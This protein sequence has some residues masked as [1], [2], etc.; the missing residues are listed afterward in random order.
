MPTPSTAGARRHR[1]W[2]LS[3][4]AL[5]AVTTLAACGSSNH[6]SSGSGSGSGSGSSGSGSGSGSSGGSPSSGSPNTTTNTGGGNATGSPITFGQLLP[7]TGTKAELSSWATHGDAAAVYDVNHN[8]GVMGHPLRSISA[9]DAGDAVDAVPAARKLLASHP[10]FIVGPFSLTVMSVIGDFDPSHTVDYVIGGTTQLDHM[11]EQYVYRTTA[12]DS[13]EVVA[14]ATY[15]IQH[16]Y[17]RAA[18]IFDNSS[19]SQGLVAPLTKSYEKQGGKVVANEKI[20]PD[21]SSYLSELTSAF[22]KNPQVV[23][24][25]FDEQT[26]STLF[27]DARQLG[28]IRVPWVGEDVLGSPGYAKAFGQPDASKYLFS[29]SGAPP[30]GPAYQHYLADYQAVYHTKQ[31]LSSSYN[32]YD[33]VI[34]SALAMTEAKS[35]DPKVWVSD[36]SK[37]SD[38][39]GT[40]CYTY[41]SCVALIKKGTKINYTGATGPED[42]NQYHNTFSG[43]AVDGFSS[44]NQLVQR[45]YV[46]AAQVSKNAG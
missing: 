8:G 15:A 43:F 26:A 2:K 41:A 6:T 28:H 31:I 46:P 5:A 34:I 22:S 12:S 10:K 33:S 45:A 23:F 25:A 21:Q 36:I 11:T 3:L 44:S 19:N 35:T 14:M 40:A 4:A 42:F 16:G 20:V 38:P 7:F 17:K 13:A 27:A 39:P 9:D 1:G 29:V 30:G 32:M 18:Y 37:V 24:C